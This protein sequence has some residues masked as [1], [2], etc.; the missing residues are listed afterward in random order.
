MLDEDPDLVAALD[1]ERL[2]AE[3]HLLDDLA[4]LRVGD[5]HPLALGLVLV[6]LGDEVAV[7]LDGQRQQVRE[8]LRAG[9]RR[10]SGW[11][12]SEPASVFLLTSCDQRGTA[13]P[14]E[15][16]PILPKRPPG[17]GEHPAARC[18]RPARA[19]NAYGGGSRP[20]LPE[21]AALVFLERS[22]EQGLVDP[23][24]EDRHA[25][26]H[27][28]RDDLTAVHTRL[29]CQLGGRQV[30]CQFLLP[31]RTTGCITGTDRADDV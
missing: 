17:R 19:A 20:W 11:W 7:L 30:I 24:L 1:A 5:V 9:R 2:Q 10:R 4:Q 14:A 31:S 25:H 28:L 26:L 21:A 16:G 23:A 13:H 15:N 29:P 6:P 22:Q 12:P 27:A 8:R 3:R 18:R